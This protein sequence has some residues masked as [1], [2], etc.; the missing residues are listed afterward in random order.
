MERDFGYLRSVVAPR[1]TMYWMYWI[2]NLDELSVTA[3]ASMLVALSLIRQPVC[4]RHH[5]QQNIF[6]GR[7]RVWILSAESGAFVDPEEKL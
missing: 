6:P 5:L 4:Y 2:I 1:D 3:F 7:E